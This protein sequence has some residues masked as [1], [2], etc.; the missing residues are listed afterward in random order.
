M[1]NIKNRPG[2]ALTALL[3]ALLISAS[4]GCD[5]SENHSGQKENSPDQGE[6]KHAHNEN[7]DAKQGKGHDKS[8]DGDHG[9]ETVRLSE[10]ELE[11]FGI[12]TSLAGPGKLNISITLPG[13]V[14]VNADKLAHVVPRVSG[15]VREV[16]ANLGDHVKLGEV[17]AVL[18]SRELS[19]A[20]AEYL[21][22]IERLSLATANYSREER[23]WRKKVSSEQDYLN[24]KQ[25]L[26]EVRIALRS[27]E[28]KLHAL[29]FTEKYLDRL[30]KHADI[31]FTRYEITA[32]FKGTVIEKHVA[33][34]EA[35][36]GDAVLFVVADLSTVWVDLSVYEKDL[37]FIK[38]G[39]KVAITAGH[40]IP[41][42]EG[43]I[44]YVG[45]IVGEQT[46]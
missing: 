1:M 31:T 45:P 44:S 30:P 2:T 7:E 40:G 43:V 35:V 15:V 21:A 41:D 3:F 36:Q 8:E 18:E 34:G 28:Q 5:S 46:R 16:R 4:S 26:A 6:E 12:Q 22:A 13:E 17:M 24:A 33:L 37:P 23:L 27:A 39:A 32:P 29:G 38:E 19:D 11:E 10:E 25:E 9:E 14:S 20:K 42:A